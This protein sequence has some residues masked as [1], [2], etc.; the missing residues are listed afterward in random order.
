MTK[1]HGIDCVLRGGRQFITPPGLRVTPKEFVKEL[2][3]APGASSHAWV[4]PAHV[5]VLTSTLLTCGGYP[6]GGPVLGGI[7]ITG[8]VAVVGSQHRLLTHCLDLWS[9]TQHP[10]LIIDSAILRQMGWCV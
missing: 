4:H 1:L 6:K 2:A 10:Y 9:Q 5:R 3:T 8:C 7:T